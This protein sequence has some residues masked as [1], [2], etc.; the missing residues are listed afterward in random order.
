MV[1]AEG[2]QPADESGHQMALTMLVQRGKEWVGQTERVALKCIHG[3]L[4]GSCCAAE[5]Q[6]CAL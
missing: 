3:Q 1:T 5:A 4:V 6:L 2:R